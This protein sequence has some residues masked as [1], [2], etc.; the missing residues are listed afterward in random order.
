ME[1]QSSRLP[2]RVAFAGIL[3]SKIK[4]LGAKVVQMGGEFSAGLNLAERTTHVVCEN[5]NSIKSKILMDALHKSVPILPP[6]W[7]DDCLNQYLQNPEA[8]GLKDIDLVW[9]IRLN[10]FSL[11]LRKSQLTEHYSITTANSND[12]PENDVYVKLEAD[13][14]DSSSFS[15][16]ESST[17]MLANRDHLKQA[18]IEFPTVSPLLVESL[19]YGPA[20]VNHII[21]LSSKNLTPEDL[22]HFDLRSKAP[23]NDWGFTNTLQMIR[24]LIIYH[25]ILIFK[26][27]STHNFSSRAYNFFVDAVIEKIQLGLSFSRVSR[28][29][30]EILENSLQDP[31]FNFA[32]VD[33]AILLEPFSSSQHP[34]LEIDET[35]EV[36]IPSLS[37][38]FS[39]FLIKV[40]SFGRISTL[41]AR[42]DFLELVR[43]QKERDFLLTS[44][45]NAVIRLA[46]NFTGNLWTDSTGFWQLMDQLAD[47][48]V[49]G[50]LET[51]AFGN[52]KSERI[53]WVLAG[54]TCKS[55][56][57]TLQLDVLSKWFNVEQVRTHL[58][59]K[60]EETPPL[61]L[62][63]LRHG[64]KPMID[65]LI[66]NQ[67]VKLSR[68]IY[69]TKSDCPWALLQSVSEGEWETVEQLT[70]PRDMYL[71]FNRS[72][73]LVAQFL[74]HAEAKPKQQE[75]KP[76][77]TVKY[78]SV[79]ML[80]ASF[81]N[82]DVFLNI[83]KR[84]NAS[85]IFNLKC[86]VEVE[87][88]YGT[89]VWT[90]YDEV[91][92]FDLALLGGYFNEAKMILEI[93]VACENK[94]G[95]P[96]YNSVILSKFLE[97]MVELNEEPHP[98]SI[99]NNSVEDTSIEST[100]SK[101]MK[102]IVALLNEDA[103]DPFIHS[104]IWPARLPYDLY[105]REW[106]SSDQMKAFMY[107][108]K[109]EIY[110]T[111]PVVTPFLCWAAWR[112]DAQ[113]ISQY[114]VTA[115]DKE[116]IIKGKTIARRESW[117]H[118]LAHGFLNVEKDRGFIRTAIACITDSS[119]FAMIDG[120]G[121]DIKTVW[122][123]I[124]PKLP[125]SS[126]LE[127]K[128]ILNL[129]NKHIEGYN[130]N[131]NGNKR[132][133]EQTESVL[134]VEKSITS[135]VVAESTANVPYF[136]VESVSIKTGGAGIS[137]PISSDINPVVAK[138]PLPPSPSLLLQSNIVTVPKKSLSETKKSSDVPKS[139]DY[140]TLV[141][142]P[143]KKAR[144]FTDGIPAKVHDP[145]AKPIVSSQIVKQVLP[146]KPAA[147]S[148]D[149]SHKV[150]KVRSQGE[151]L[152]EAGV[153]AGVRA[154]VKVGAGVEV[155]V[156]AEVEAEVG[157]EKASMGR[158]LSRDRSVGN[159]GGRFA[160]IYRPS[161]GSTEAL[162]TN[163]HRDESKV[164]IATRLGGLSAAPSAPQNSS[165]SIADRL[166]K[167]SKSPGSI[168]NRLGE[169]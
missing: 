149:T 107:A 6:K 34:M 18:I 118:L 38:L 99:Y 68:R 114:M 122:E 48:G 102:E 153:K 37:R 5:P 58:I 36:V 108:D 128:K 84:L 73:D 131:K 135:L 97:W 106:I 158:S 9:P 137:L 57:I 13:L 91:S 47:S 150:K 44:L 51:I 161:L 76:K 62:R 83:W 121:R 25:S 70:S 45:A 87:W 66:R 115:K 134:E 104:N 129:I 113:L 133:V 3:P 132:K 82:S 138:I 159:D 109:F 139:V 89:G 74:N 144:I 4:E 21:R 23:A 12:L 41:L 98:P 11:Y 81:G 169:K 72:D 56:D 43:S 163:S 92:Q 55:L 17:K 96:I 152:A 14:P 126:Q 112:F 27:G 111:N 49:D 19:L 16:V 94:K 42:P 53:F 164:P 86:T 90:N 147:A 117:L 80:N 8:F 35:G 157:K 30:T 105:S 100:S 52:D 24:C 167:T 15:S 50:A 168:A 165:I 140:S 162:R 20:S 141:D 65:F 22:A 120:N 63:A 160:N 110:Y 75:L 123:E 28:F 31:N 71:L 32:E 39:A 146:A 136:S 1:S 145:S 95:N 130:I 116:A 85:E 46:K 124:V 59:P 119:V 67:Q 29:V 7:V 60:N 2:L 142:H 127:A 143:F 88:E 33:F 156:E 61:M 151:T 79:S 40:A 93:L 148:Y 154:G 101:L 78:L 10:T 155:G 64:S 166:G 77:W 125:K 69:K 26:F 54:V 103:I